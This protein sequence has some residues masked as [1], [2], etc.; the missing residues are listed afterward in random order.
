VSIDAA[1]VISPLALRMANS[2]RTLA[3]RHPAVGARLVAGTTLQPVRGAPQYAGGLVLCHGCLP[4]DPV[5]RAHAWSWARSRQRC[6]TCRKRPQ[7]RARG[8]KGSRNDA[9]TQ[10]VGGIFM[11]NHVSSATR[12]VKRA[13]LATKVRRRRVRRAVKRVAVR[14]GMKRAA[15]R[16]VVR[17]A[18]ARRAVKR[19]VVRR[20]VKR[21]VVRR[22]VRRAVARRAVKRAVARRAIKRV[23]ARRAVNRAVARRVVRR[24]GGRRALKRAAARKLAAAEI[25]RMALEFREASR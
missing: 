4:A 13:A 6:R 25:R 9:C 7:K 3:S 2:S 19:A 10:Q 24:A 18:A 23:V 21:A 12:R 1:H 16:R 17:R 14:R 20:A 22:A 8:A 15:V 11:A 5:Q